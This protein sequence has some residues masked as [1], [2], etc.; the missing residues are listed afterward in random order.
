MLADYFCHKK[1]PTSIKWRTGSNV[2]RVYD[3]Y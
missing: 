2:F 3:L 1:F